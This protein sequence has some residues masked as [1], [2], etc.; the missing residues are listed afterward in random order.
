ML[1]LQHLDADL[2]QHLRDLK[3]RSVRRMHGMHALSMRSATRR[4]S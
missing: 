3:V 4:A 2:V 1:V